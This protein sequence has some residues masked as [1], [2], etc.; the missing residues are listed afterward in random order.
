LANCV[1]ISAERVPV[2]VEIKS[3]VGV[4][5]KKS[6][7][8]PGMMKVAMKNSTQ[9]RMTIIVESAMERPSRW[10]ANSRS[11]L[12]TAIRHSPHERHNQ[13]K[14]NNPPIASRM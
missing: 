8:S 13:R 14:A 3:N 4:A 2:G 6:E 12:K 7:G 1:I 10:A 9:K 5:T 11:R